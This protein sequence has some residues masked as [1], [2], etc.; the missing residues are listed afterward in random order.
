MANLI[1]L[2]ET[3]TSFQSE[4]PSIQFSLIIYFSIYTTAFPVPPIFNQKYENT[5]VRINDPISLNCPVHGDRPIQI[6][7]LINEKPIELIKDSR[8]QLIDSS[9]PQMLPTALRNRSFSSSPILHIDLAHRQDSALYTCLA[10]NR[11]GYDQWRVQLRVEEPPSR[12]A[13]PVA[14]AITSRSVQLGWQAP[15][16]GNSEITK[17]WV[18]CHH[19]QSGRKFFI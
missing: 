1:K 15:F 19:S 17:Y 14:S 16:N 13:P 8:I 11:Y 18:T 12:P 6:R 4:T 3:V 7:W 10:S 5:N 9:S 2:C